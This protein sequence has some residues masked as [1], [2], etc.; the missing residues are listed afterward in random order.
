MD[1]NYFLHREQVERMRA[2]RA[3]NDNARAAHAGLAEGYRALVDGHRRDV[4]A[5]AGP[6]PGPPAPAP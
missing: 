1:V 2:D 5:A 3:A 4:L 6:P